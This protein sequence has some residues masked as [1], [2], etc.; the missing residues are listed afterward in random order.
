MM[1]INK[2]L[3][4]LFLLFCANTTLAQDELVPALKNGKWAVLDTSLN[5]LTPYQFDDVKIVNKKFFVP[6]QGGYFGLFDKRNKQILPIE[7]QSIYSSSPF[8]LIVKQ[9]NLFGLY[10]FEGKMLLPCVFDSIEMLNP[11]LA[12]ALKNE[13]WQHYNIQIKQIS[14]FYDR[15]IDLG[16]QYFQLQRNE[17]KWLY[18]ATINSLSSDFA[19]IDKQSKNLFFCLRNDNQKFVLYSN[20]QFQTFATDSFYYKQLNTSVFVFRKNNM[21]SVFNESTVTQVE[22]EADEILP[23]FNLNNTVMASFLAGNYYFFKKDG[24]IGMLDDGFNIVIKAIYDGI[25]LKNSELLVTRN[26][27][28]GLVS[29]DGKIKVPANY[30]DFSKSENYWIVQNDSKY[31]VLDEN[32]RELIKPQ[33]DEILLA[34][35]NKFIVS[36]NR[37]SGLVDG[38]N[39]ILIPLEYQHIATND[40]GC[41]LKKDNKFGL[42]TPNGE[43]ILEVKY[44]NISKLNNRYFKYSEDGKLGIIGADGKILAKPQY[45]EI[46]ATSN[47]GIFYVFTTELLPATRKELKEKFELDINVP[48]DDGTIKWYQTGIINSFGEILLDPEYYEVQVSMDTAANIILAKDK[49]SA[50]VISFEPSGKLIE[51]TEYK[52]YI[53]VKKGRTETLRNYWLQGGKNNNYGLFSS[54]GTQLLDYQYQRITRNFLNNPDLVIVSGLTKSLGIVNERTAKIF[55]ADAYKTIHQEDFKYSRLAR[56]VKKSG[57]TVLIDTLANIVEKGIGYMDDFSDK[58]TRVNKG[59]KV[60]KSPIKVYMLQNE[61]IEGEERSYIDFERADFKVCTGGKWGVMDTSGTWLIQPKYQFLQNY[62][63]DVF[64]AEKDKKWGVIS[65]L[66]EQIVEFGFDEIRFFTDTESKNW[67]NIPFYQSRIGRKWGVIDSLGNIIV[68]NEYDGIETLTCNGKIYFKTLLDNKSNLFGLVD[69]ESKVVLTPRFLFIGPFSNG[70]A[71]IQTEKACWQ[72]INNQINLL[73]S[74]CFVET[75]DFKNGLAA[76]KNKKGWGFIDEFGALVIPAQFIEV[77]D[78]NEG[79]APVKLKVQAKL[80]G[81]IASNQIFMVI[82]K[83][84]QIVYNTKA[85]YCSEVSN[86]RIIVRKDKKFQLITVSGKKVLPRKY[87]QIIENKEYGLY[88][89]QNSNHQFALYNQEAELLVPFGK[90]RMYSF[91][92]EGL[93]Y[94]EGEK[95]GFIDTLGIFKFAIDCQKSGEFKE[96]LAAIKI[97]NNWGYIDTNGKIVITPQYADAGAFDQGI[98]KVMDNQLQWSCIDKNGNLHPPIAE[99]NSTEFQIVTVNGLK[100]IVDKSGKTIVNPVAEE[101]GL[102]SENYAPFGIRKQYGLFDVKGNQIAETKYMFI[103]K[104]IEGIIRLENLEEIRYVK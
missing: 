80:F 95:Q 6:W 55:L 71:R 94:V 86:G 65:P 103:K 12:I 41:I 70:L 53:T 38:K 75:R 74:E 46:K 9:Y 3:S 99:S 77:G 68:K 44:L 25:E 24:K 90:Y 78:F 5:L 10:D 8:C 39:K 40:Y 56:C 63:R 30:D 17:S 73:P 104:M 22:I 89:V 83:N 91:F 59:G 16:D 1:L 72:F 100:G 67:F 29:L 20:G 7:F 102:F 57:A 35:S 27:K 11:N 87:V 43:F 60:S 33:Y 19:S 47:P 61:D 97:K 54:S 42:C 32:N 15:I 96:G 37:K 82:D 79:L 28:R 26:G 62:F 58:Y 18:N 93:C 69:K 2:Y 14:D 13:K 81:L 36:L 45:T 4:I 98:A 88:I 101:I 92:S 76:V 49:N 64:I 84:G 52:N 66:D 23:S 34:F 85:E 31:G 50:I 51:K 48:T 21:I